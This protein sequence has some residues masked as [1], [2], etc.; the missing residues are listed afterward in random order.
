[1]TDGHSS[2]TAVPAPS[3]EGAAGERKLFQILSGIAADPARERVSVGD[4]LTAMEDRA[5]G[6]LMLVFALPNLL[7]MPPGISGILGVPLVLLTAQL[8]LGQRPWLPK[9]IAKMSM[10]RVDF[11][12]VLDRAGPWLARVEK[13]LRPRLGLLVHPPA[14]Y[15]IGVACLLLT[16]ILIL[17]I[18]LGNILPA[19]AICMFSFGLLDKD[20]L[21]AV[22]GAIT[23]IVSVVIVGGVVFALGKGAIFVIQNA[24]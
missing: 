4:L 20:G 8:M 12:A 17:P 6:A 7:P 15:A 2:S 24:L 19:L 22:V 3:G 11:S 23:T 14:E 18:P 1:M 10:L 9:V 21:W 5:F 13:L 16:V